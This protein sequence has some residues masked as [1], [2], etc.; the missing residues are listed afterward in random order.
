MHDRE[1]LHRSIISAIPN[2]L[3][4][5][6]A[7]GTRSIPYRVSFPRDPAKHVPP[8]LALSRILTG[9]DRT[10]TSDEYT[11]LTIK[12]IVHIGRSPAGITQACH[13]LDIPALI[14]AINARHL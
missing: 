2:V 5:R 14:R 7:D 12:L 6:S 9:L 11:A 10:I 1:T 3:S 8:T 4:G 13:T